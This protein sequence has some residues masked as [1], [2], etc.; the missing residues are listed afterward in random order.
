MAGESP[1]SP[2]QVERWL[3]ERL[4]VVADES[5]RIRLVRLVHRRALVEVPHLWAP[6]AR[7]AWNASWQV[8]DGGTVRFRTRRTWG[9]LT[10]G[11]MWLRAGSSG[12]Q[13]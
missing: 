1:F 4:T 8:R 7:E 12:P 11:K 10:K 2:R 9:T 3:R 5:L 6:Q 13:R